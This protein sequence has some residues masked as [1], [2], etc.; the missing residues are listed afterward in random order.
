MNQI[1]SS[2]RLKAGSSYAKNE[3]PQE[4]FFLTGRFFGNI[5]LMLSYDKT[6]KYYRIINRNVIRCG[7]YVTLPAYFYEGELFYARI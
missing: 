7:T 1:I 5:S 4:T 3:N 2:T 6:D